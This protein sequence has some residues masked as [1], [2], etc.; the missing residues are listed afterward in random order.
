MILNMF[1]NVS[2]PTVDDAVLYED[3]F[4]PSLWRESPSEILMPDSHSSWKIF[5]DHFIFSFYLNKG[6]EYCLFHSVSPVMFGGPIKPRIP[7]VFSTIDRLFSLPPLPLCGRAPLVHQL[8]LA[9]SDKSC[10]I[11]NRRRRREQTR[12]SEC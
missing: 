1:F 3:H 9:R 10:S 11:F 5:W 8:S 7:P 2:F 6:W 12:G 4:L